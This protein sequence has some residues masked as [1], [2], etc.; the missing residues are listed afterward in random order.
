MGFLL[1]LRWPRL[2]LALPVVILAIAVA[3]WRI[4][5]DRVGVWLLALPTAADAGGKAAGRLELWN[6][7]FDM[8]QDFPFTG[9]GLNTFPVVVRVLYPLVVNDPNTPVPHAHDFLLQVAIDLGLPGL[10][11]FLLLLAAAAVG[12]VRAWKIR[13][14]WERGLV[15]GVGA[16]LIG[17]LIFGL[18]DA[19]TLGAKPG[20]FLWAMLGAAVALGQSPSSALVQ[21][22]VRAWIEWGLFSLACALGIFITVTNLVMFPD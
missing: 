21:R 12:L 9:I 2:V 15:A 16:G 4:G 7:A 17:Q 13:Q 6:R 11:C 20:I 18:T 10:T 3:I 19:V 1:V 22:S 14:G 5:F 8:I